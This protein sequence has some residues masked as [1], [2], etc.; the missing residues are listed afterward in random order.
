MKAICCAVAAVSLVSCAQMNHLKTATVS[1]VS[2]V[3][4]ASKDSFAKLMPQRIP[5]VEVR[6]NELKEIKTGREQA[7][8]FEKERRKGFWGNLFQ[9]PTDFKEPELPVES[10]SMDGELLPP[11]LE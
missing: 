3:G 6:Q 1:G 9:G 7:V 4:Q 8:A 11:K 2:K 10:A 5:V